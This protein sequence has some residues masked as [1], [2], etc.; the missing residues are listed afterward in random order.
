MKFQWLLLPIILFLIGLVYIYSNYDIPNNPK[1][2]ESHFNDSI[3]GSEHYPLKEIKR[4]ENSNTSI[5]LFGLSIKRIFWG[6]WLWR[7]G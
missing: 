7:K 5:A 1:A 6:T 2:V 3:P 4:L